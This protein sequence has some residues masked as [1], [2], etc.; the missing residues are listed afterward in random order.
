VSV[1][2]GEGKVPILFGS[3]SINAGTRTRGA[4]LARPDLT[5]EWPTIV[6]VPDAWGVTSNVKAL[7]RKL[8]RQGF[9]VVAPDFHRDAPPAPGVP[10]DEAREALAEVPAGEV[11]LVL[12][13]IVDF[14]TNVAGFWSS[15]EHGFGVLG[16]GAGATVAAGLAVRS[17]A[18]AFGVLS[19]ELLEPAVELD[20]YVGAVLGLYG[21]E[22]DVVDL[23]VVSTIRDVVPQTELVLYG[24]VGHDFADDYQDGFDYDAAEDAAERL[25]GFFEK[26]LPPAP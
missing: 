25:S 7:C 4:Y 17:R 19:G 13:D 22:D 24:G 8:A 6:L 21:K 5:G 14:I 9:A 18:A 15:A 12:T 20:G 1:L 16:V 3:T 11:A 2:K 23:D 26:H 10:L